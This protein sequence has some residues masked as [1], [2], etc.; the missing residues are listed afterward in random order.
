MKKI[1]I[2]LSLFCAFFCCK[3]QKFTLTDFNIWQRSWL[4]HKHGLVGVAGSDTE[5]LVCKAPGQIPARSIRHQH[6]GSKVGYG[7]EQ[8]S[9]LLVTDS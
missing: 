9:F 1:N 2:F 8:S 3:L 4:A 7:S 6:L 5:A